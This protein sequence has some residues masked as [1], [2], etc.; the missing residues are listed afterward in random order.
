MPV[1]LRSELPDIANGMKRRANRGLKEGAELVAKTAALNAPYD[2]DEDEVHLR[3]RIHVERRGTGEYAVVAGDDEAWYGHLIEHG[4]ARGGKPGG[5]GERGPTPPRPFLVPAL[6]V[7]FE[8][9]VRLVKEAI[10]P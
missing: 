5:R 3:D 10:I 7:H 1:N 6:E 8:D 2:P 4:T 9:I